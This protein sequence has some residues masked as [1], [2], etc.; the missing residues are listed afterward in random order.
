MIQRMWTTVRPEGLPS[1]SHVAPPG[2]WRRRGSAHDRPV[3]RRRP[4]EHRMTMLFYARCWIVNEC[5]SQLR[6]DRSAAGEGG[7]G[8]LADADAAVVGRDERVH[9]HAAGRRSRRPLSTTSVSRAFWNTPPVSATV[10][11]PWSRGDVDG[12]RRRRPGRSPRGSRPRSRPAARPRRRSASTPATSGAGSSTSTPSV[13]GD[14]IVPSYAG[15][16]RGRPCGPAPPAR[17]PPG[18]RS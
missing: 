6:A 5:V 11:R 17:S 3:P 14:V 13:V 18:P 7:D 4:S 9:Q 12:R 16:R 2:A 10:S 15:A 1:R 8:G